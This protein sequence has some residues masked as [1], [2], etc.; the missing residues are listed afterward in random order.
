MT[1]EENS[2]YLRERGLERHRGGDLAEARRLYLQAIAQTPSDAASL[3]LLGV[4]AQQ[5][6]NAQESVDW[7]SK[8]LERFPEAGRE[9]ALALVNR[10]FVRSFAGEIDG[11]LGDCEEGTEIALAIA[12]DAIV[13]RGYQHKHLTLL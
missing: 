5:Q 13:A 9:R 7:L 6:G 1:A 3:N 2:A 12:D 11:A 8:A 4:I 10:G